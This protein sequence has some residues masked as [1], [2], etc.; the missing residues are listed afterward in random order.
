M[1]D[2]VKKHSFCRIRVYEELDIIAPAIYAAISRARCFTKM[3]GSKGIISELINTS[4]Q[5]K[6]KKKTW[7]TLTKTWLN[8]NKID[9]NQNIKETVLAVKAA[10]YRRVQERDRSIIGSLAA[11]FNWTSGKELRKAE[12]NP[13]TS[14]LGLITMF[15]LRT[16]TFV[17]TNEMVI[18]GY[19]SPEYKN[20]CIMCKEETHE[21]LKH[22]LLDCSALNEEINSTISEIIYLTTNI[23]TD[24]THQL[25]LKIL[26]GGETPA[27]GRKPAEVIPCTA[28]YLSAYVVKRSAFIKQLKT[29]T[30]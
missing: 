19:F 1:K 25:T 27:F 20:K 15:K 6:S 23:S 22:I 11:K 17:T 9:L 29:M 26:L 14:T 12:L 16:G 30:M 2:L 13:S 8:T 28:K 18:R 4:D 24:A 21:D 10:Y 5:F 7:A 3:K